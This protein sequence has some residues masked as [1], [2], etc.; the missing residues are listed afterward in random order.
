MCVAAQGLDEITLGRDG[1][2]AAVVLVEHRRAD[3]DTMLH[4]IGDKDQIV[5]GNLYG[6]DV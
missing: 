5:R 1:T 3:D 4:L 2:D 6:V